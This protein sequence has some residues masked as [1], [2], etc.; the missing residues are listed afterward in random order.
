MSYGIRKVIVSKACNEFDEYGIRSA[1]GK[2]I[3]VICGNVKICNS[4]AVAVRYL[5]K[6]GYDAFGN[7]I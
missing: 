6:N 7:A 5:K 1:G 4:L 3:A 2:F